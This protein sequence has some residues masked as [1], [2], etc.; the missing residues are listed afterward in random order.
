M[1]PLYKLSQEVWSN[2]KTLR[3]LDGRTTT[4]G[5]GMRVGFRHLY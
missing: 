3:S 4:V 2:G 1:S 5:S